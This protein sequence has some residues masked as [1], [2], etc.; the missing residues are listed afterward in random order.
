MSLPIE[1]KEALFKVFKESGFIRYDSGKFIFRMGKKT[2]SSSSFLKYLGAPETLEAAGL[3]QLALRVATKKFDVAEIEPEIKEYSKTN[4]EAALNQAEVDDE[5]VEKAEDLSGFIKTLIP[6]I[7]V[8]PKAKD[9]L[10]LLDPYKQNRPV[11]DIDSEIFM[12]LTGRTLQELMFDGDVKKVMTCFDPYTLKSLFVRESRS[13]SATTWHVNYY[14]P[15]RW[16]FVEALP[17][18]H[19]FIFTLI[20][21]LFP[22]E[23]ER[24]YVLDWLHY[25]LAY[26]NDTMLCLIGPRGTGKGI[27][28][29]DI[30]S[31]LIGEDYREI[32]NQ[33]IL[34]DKF[35]GAFKNKR[36]VFFD[37]VDISGDRELNKIKAFCNDK[38]A[39]EEKGEDSETIDNYTSLGL[40]SNNKKEFRA[41]PQERRFSVPEVV[42]KPLLEVI[43]EEE[44]EAFCKRIAEPESLEIAEFGN[45]LLQRVPRYSSRKPLKGAYFFNLCRLSMPEWKTYIIDF[46]IN[47]GVVGEM[48]IMSNLIKKFRKQYGETAAFATKRGSIE[49]FLG[50]YLHEGKYRIGKVVDCWDKQRSRDSF[51]IVPSEDFLRTF[52]RNY[53][54]EA[55]TTDAEAMEA[56]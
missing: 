29:K 10:I 32:V 50:D 17:K 53:N 22:N 9:R 6:A 8:V 42:E 14:I 27:L 12:T 15:P 30:L 56:L 3:F 23:S 5:D 49:T 39:M 13:G 41:E 54:I 11:V 4:H 38:I 7:N 25:A 26:R 33:E 35:N 48:A 31:A 16:R 52:G 45:W 19:G 18:F 20:N 24:E 55:E 40:S 34:T 21:H 36:Y 28:L 37:E 51:A 2:N 43:P 46:F 47:E 1:Q 44:V